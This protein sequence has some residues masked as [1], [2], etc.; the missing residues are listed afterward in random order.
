MKRLVT[1]FFIL[2]L[3]LTS[4]VAWSQVARLDN[5]TL[6]YRVVFKWGMVNKTAGRVTVKMTNTPPD[7][8]KAVVYARSEPWADRIY[9][10]RDTLT[11]VMSSTTLVPR[12]YERIAHEDGKYVCDRINFTQVK[13][14]FS[15]ECT[16]VRRD[17]KDSEVKTLTT[18]LEA[19]GMTVDFL[20]AFY[21]LRTL[22]FDSMLP[23]H[24]ITINIFSGRRKEL[25]RFTFR[26]IETVE[27]AGKKYNAYKVQFSFTSDGKKE[28]SDAVTAWITTDSRRIPVQVEGKLKVGK[29]R[30]I[31][32]P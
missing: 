11:S 7:T 5:E 13:N 4:S 21:Y 26:G 8:Y 22:N 9:S 14:N 3:L 23:G 20:S 12:F 31:L 19:T 30:C 1:L 25:L 16:R 2:G 32:E 15:A 18:N 24:A 6:H 17:K 10:L 28:T 29:M 27:T